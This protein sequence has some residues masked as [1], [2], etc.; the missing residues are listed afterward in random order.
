VKYYLFGRVLPVCESKG[1]NQLNSGTEDGDREEQ[2]G[3]RIPTFVR[4]D[5]LGQRGLAF[6]I[7]ALRKNELQEQVQM[8]QN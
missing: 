3:I 4:R 8:P 5:V 1:N 6:R 7:T 2:R